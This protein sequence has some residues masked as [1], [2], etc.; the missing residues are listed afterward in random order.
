MKMKRNRGFLIFLFI[1]GVILSI[2]MSIFGENPKSSSYLK[3]ESYA[4]ADY[5]YEWVEENVSADEMTEE[6]T[7]GDTTDNEQSEYIFQD[8]AERY[9]TDE[10]LENLSLQQI[11][12]AKNEI[13]ARHGRMF[14]KQELMDYFSSKSWYEGT[15]AAEAFDESILNDYERANA[16]KLSEKE[17]EISSEGYQL[18]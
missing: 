10:E 15:I 1:V 4:V 12:Y 17:H 6:P 16:K 5:L 14:Q 18:Y 13:Y 9:L 3:I 2:V 11:N 8:S 7:E